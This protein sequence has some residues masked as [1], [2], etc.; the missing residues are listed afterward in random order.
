MTD[1]FVRARPWEKGLAREIIAPGL[2]HSWLG[3]FPFW[4]LANYFLLPLHFSLDLAIQKAHGRINKLHWFFDNRIVR[5]RK[6]RSIE[7]TPM[8]PILS[9]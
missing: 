4:E 7:L 5:E 3:A 2:H 9:I 8:F 6:H 1:V